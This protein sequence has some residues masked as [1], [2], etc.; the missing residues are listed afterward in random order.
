MRGRRSREPHVRFFPNDLREREGRECPP[1]K[2]T[3]TLTGLT[4]QVSP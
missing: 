3:H 4:G 2:G 1:L